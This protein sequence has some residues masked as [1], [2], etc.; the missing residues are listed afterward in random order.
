MASEEQEEKTSLPPEEE[1]VDVKLPASESIGKKE[2]EVPDC[3]VHSVVVYPDRA[4]VCDAACT[5]YHDLHFSCAIFNTL[6]C[7]IAWYKFNNYLKTQV[8]VEK[9]HSSM[10]ISSRKSLHNKQA[11][12]CS[13][14]KFKPF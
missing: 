2:V 9:N 6:L 5:K 13:M 12:E 8:R 4:E 1:E 7:W 10:H 14:I 3:P 11:T